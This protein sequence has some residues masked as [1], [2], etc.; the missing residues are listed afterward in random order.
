MSYL[1]NLNPIAQEALYDSI[2]LAG[3]FSPGVV[4][5]S[6]HKRVQ[7]YD[8]K[9]A[10]GSAGASV[11]RKGESMSE[12]TCTFQLSIDPVLGIDDFAAWDDFLLVLQSATAKKEP[13]ALPILHPDLLELGI[14]QVVPKEIGGK[15]HDGKGGAT[16]SVTFL[17]YLPP[18]PKGGSP[19][20]KGGK[21]D[22]NSDVK[23]QIDDELKKAQATP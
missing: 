1:D 14:V 21:A 5:V 7:K 20:P 8:V 23:K 16:V 19:K 15:V 4:K 18:K 11:T 3:A 13:T 22:P 2:I 6:G 10:D 9:E 17:E 12:F